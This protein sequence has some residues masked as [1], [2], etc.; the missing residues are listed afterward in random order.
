MHF[1][2]FYIIKTQNI[3]SFYIP[4]SWN[5]KDLNLFQSQHCENIKYPYFEV[6]FALIFELL[7][8]M[9]KMLN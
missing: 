6:S 7:F 8:T 4:S 3:I 9:P 2:L 5:T 1:L